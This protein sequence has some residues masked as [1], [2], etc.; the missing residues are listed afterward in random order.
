MALSWGMPSRLWSDFPG[1]EYGMVGGC[2]VCWPEEA[3]E[4]L[5]YRHSQSIWG[6]RVSVKCRWGCICTLLT[7]EETSAKEQI[8]LIC[9]LSLLA[10]STDYRGIRRTERIAQNT[11]GSE[12]EGQCREAFCDRAAGRAVPQPWTG[13][14]LSGAKRRV[15]LPLTPEC[16]LAQ[17]L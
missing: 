12:T 15:I 17:L 8:L 13:T 11:L 10:G 3:A 16:Y 9:R 4:K 7:G 5:N 14:R 1:A 6:L 2:D